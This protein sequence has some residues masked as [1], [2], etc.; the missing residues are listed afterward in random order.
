[1]SYVTLESEEVRRL[2]QA[3]LDDIN[4]A[5]N[6]IKAEAVASMRRNPFRRLSAWL[7]FK[8]RTDDELWEGLHP[9]AKMSYDLSYG[10]QE[11]VAI[12]LLRAA[13]LAPAVNVSVDDLHLIS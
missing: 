7:G 9:L 3:T 1:M 6:R 4:A 13:S 11:T 10:R 12:H 5:R 8:Q 2:A